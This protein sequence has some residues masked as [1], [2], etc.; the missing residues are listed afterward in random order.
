M[1]ERTYMC[2]VKEL[3]LETI[4]V[5]DVRHH[6]IEDSN[7]MTSLEYLRVYF[8]LVTSY[9]NFELYYENT[10]FENIISFFNLY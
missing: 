8:L 7:V 5:N 3:T 9:L 6:R 10:E 4:R 1:E 2:L